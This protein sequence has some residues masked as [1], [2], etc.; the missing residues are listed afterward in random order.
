MPPNPNNAAIMM[1]HCRTADNVINGV[2]L[3]LT[4]IAR[5]ADLETLLEIIPV[6][7]PRPPIPRRRSKRAWRPG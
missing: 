6:S 5:I 3:T 4:D 1:L 2:V 7:S